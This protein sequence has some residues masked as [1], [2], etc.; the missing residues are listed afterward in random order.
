[1]LSRPHAICAA[2]VDNSVIQ[3]A[4]NPN[5]AGAGRDTSRLSIA[6]SDMCGGRGDIFTQGNLISRSKNIYLAVSTPGNPQ[7]FSGN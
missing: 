3:T 1:M 5:M 6:P 4:L 2:A 7:D